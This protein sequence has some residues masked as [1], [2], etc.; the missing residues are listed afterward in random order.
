MDYVVQ[1]HLRGRE[2][3]FHIVTYCKYVV[4]YI[5]WR[6]VHFWIFAFTSIYFLP[7]LFENQW[8]IDQDKTYVKMERRFFG[9]KGEWCSH[10]RRIQNTGKH[11]TWKK[12]FAKIINSWKSLSI[13]TKSSIFDVWQG[14]EYASGHY[15]VSLM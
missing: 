5:L 6:Y 14:S 4:K 9:R 13:F 8:N 2:N 10:Q 1:F 11:L 3:K 15:A 12:L 7:C